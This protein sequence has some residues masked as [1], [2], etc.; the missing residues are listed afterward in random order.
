MEVVEV[1]IE[2]GEFVEGTTPA[3]GI[4]DRGRDG[5]SVVDVRQPGLQTGPVLHVESS[6]QVHD[7]RVEPARRRRQPVEHRREDRGVVLALASHQSPVGDVVRGTE[8]THRLAEAAH[9]GVD[10]PQ[11]KTPGDHRPGDVERDAVLPRIDGLGEHLLAGAPHGLSGGSGFVQPA[12]VAV[13]AFD[14]PFHV[15]AGDLVRRGPGG[16]LGGDRR[17][18]LGADGLDRLVSPVHVE[19]QG[20]ETHLVEA[21][22]HHVE[23]GLFLGDEE[24]LPPF[25]EAVGDDVGDGLGLAR[26]GRPLKDEG[27]AAGRP[28]DGFELGT[29]H[30]QRQSGAD[31]VLR[32]DVGL[33]HGVLERVGGRLDQVLDDG[34]GQELLPVLGQVAPHFQGGELQQRDTAVGLDAERQGVGEQLFTHPLE[35]G[36][37]VDA[38]V[39]GGRVGEH[40][41]LDTEVASQLLLQA[42][43]GLH[44]G[45]GFGLE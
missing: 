12:R 36:L 16:G 9:P 27:A 41:D 38:G 30:G 26:A 31:L 1:A 28:P 7:G 8:L 43:V 21:G 13:E 42:V 24:H 23:G 34:V 19:A 33:G 3:Q 4:D 5:G 20:P 35:H 22:T 10:L 17:V 37:Q 39:V 11:P 44:L 15:L 2:R 45:A 32:D 6:E 25:G 40:G 29:V 18:E 14:G